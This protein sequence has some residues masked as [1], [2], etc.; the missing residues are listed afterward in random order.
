MMPVTGTV[1]IFDCEIYPDVEISNREKHVGKVI[2]VKDGKYV[3]VTIAGLIKINDIRGL[4]D[5]QI[6]A[7]KFRIRFK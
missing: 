2:F 3:V 7:K 6:K 1:R 4:G 5:V